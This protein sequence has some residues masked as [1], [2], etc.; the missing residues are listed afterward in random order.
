MHCKWLLNEETKTFIVILKV[1]KENRNLCK[2]GIE[3]II[4]C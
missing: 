2:L 4:F 1:L 3:K